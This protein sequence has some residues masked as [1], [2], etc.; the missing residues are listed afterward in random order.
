MEH[1]MPKGLT[2]NSASYCDLLESHLKPTIRSKRR[3]LLFS[4]VLL[5][6]DNARPYKVRTTAE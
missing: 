1:Y 5:H 3:G 6:H 4:D 2:V